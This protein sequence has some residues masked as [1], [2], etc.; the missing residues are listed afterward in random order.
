MGWSLGV[1]VGDQTLPREF[2]EGRGPALEPFQTVLF[3][4]S[5]PHPPIPNGR[6][7]HVSGM[8]TDVIG[9]CTDHGRGIEV[10]AIC[11]DTQFHRR[12]D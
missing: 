7:V 11:I 4:I 5:P 9:L 6:D 1:E 10:M 2:I 12:P 8:L 3:Y